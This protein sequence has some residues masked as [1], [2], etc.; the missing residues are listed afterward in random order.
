MCKIK[1]RIKTKYKNIVFT[2]NLIYTNFSFI[3]FFHIFTSLKYLPR[4]QT[5]SEYNVENG[6]INIF[7]FIFCEIQPL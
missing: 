4:I 6:L 2:Y 3:L 1:I 7:K 5:M